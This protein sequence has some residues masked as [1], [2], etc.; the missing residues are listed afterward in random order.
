MRLKKYIICIGFLMLLFVRL[1]SYVQEELLTRVGQS[2][3]SS[4][5]TKLFKL[6]Y[7]KFYKHI[8][9]FTNRYKLLKRNVVEFRVNFRKIFGFSRKY[10]NLKCF[11]TLNPTIPLVWNFTHFLFHFFFQKSDVINAWASIP[12]NTHYESHFRKNPTH[13]PPPLIGRKFPPVMKGV[14]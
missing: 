8:L 12:E 9:N 1:I 2:N 11:Q 3:Q 5:K 14:H 13:C 7:Q 6:F 4:K 10:L